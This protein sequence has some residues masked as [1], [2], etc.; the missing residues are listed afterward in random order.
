M[1][2]SVELCFGFESYFA[3]TLEQELSFSSRLFGVAVVIFGNW[4]EFF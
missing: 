3:W 2:V 4:G 1:V